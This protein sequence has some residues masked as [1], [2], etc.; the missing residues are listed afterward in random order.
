MY[1]GRAMSSPLRF[2]DCALNGDGTR[3]EL[4]VNSTD[5][6]FYTGS[7]MCQDDCGVGLGCKPFNGA[8]RL[9]AGRH[10]GSCIAC[11]R[12]PHHLKPR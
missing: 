9:R 2:E 12:L 11:L 5:N 1:D 4:T 10:A 8:W 3:Y 6:P 7:V